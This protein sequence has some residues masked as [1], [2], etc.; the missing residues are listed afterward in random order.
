[1]PNSLCCSQIADRH[2]TSTKNIIAA[3][4]SLLSF[5]PEII[6]IKR[7][8]Q[9]KARAARKKITTPFIISFRLKT[10]YNDELIREMT[11]SCH[12]PAFPPKSKFPICLNLIINQ[13]V[14][15]PDII[16][17]IVV[18][19]IVL[20]FDFDLFFND[21]KSISTM[22]KLIRRLTKVRFARIDIQRGII[23]SREFLIPLLSVIHLKA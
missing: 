21:A 11:V 20:Y 6:L 10:P 18:H 2:S 14:K 19:R 3:N 7:N 16:K 13:T 23:T 22:E 1:M 17:M 15:K 5:F 9:N 12:S 8:R 4:K